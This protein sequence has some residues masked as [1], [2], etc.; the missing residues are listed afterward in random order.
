MSP[1]QATWKNQSPDACNVFSFSLQI[2]G[3]GLSW[4]ALPPAEPCG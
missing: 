3:A 1:Q 2:H 4:E